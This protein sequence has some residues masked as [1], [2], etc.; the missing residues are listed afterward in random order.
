MN[1]IEL[2]LRIVISEIEA[3]VIRWEFYDVKWESGA[4]TEWR[5]C[6]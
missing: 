5:K 1:V 6:T 3:Q 4:E 2:F